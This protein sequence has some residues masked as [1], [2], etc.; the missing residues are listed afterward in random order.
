M[1]KKIVRDLLRV[2]RFLFEAGVVDYFSGNLSVRWK[3]KIFI[4][5]SGSPL[6]LL[7]PQDILEVNPKKPLVGKPSSEFVVHR[8]IYKGTPWTAV[9]HAHPPAVVKLA[10][11]L[12][13]KFF[14][15]RDNEGKL[16]LEKVPILRVEKPS[17]SEELARAVAE[18]LKSFPCAV[19]YSHGVFCGGK[20]LWK[21]A[22]Y[23][24]A[25]ENSAKLFI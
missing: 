19:V 20:D 16:L 1:R 6:P 22:G 18:A 7:T 21:A 12:K 13:G 4:T 17:A 15:P 24:T 25:L 9:A 11:E 5:R 10:F 2:G 23:I 8:E 3:E 14:T